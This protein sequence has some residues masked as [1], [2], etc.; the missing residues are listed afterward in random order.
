MPLNDYILGLN[1][2]AEFDLEVENIDLGATHVLTNE[3]GVY[4]FVLRFNG[5]SYRIYIGKA[6]NLNSRIANYRSNFQPHSPNDFKIRAFVEFINNEGY[7]GAELDLYF[8]PVPV[9]ELKQSEYDIIQR[10]NPILNIP[11]VGRLHIPNEY[12]FLKDAFIEFY[13]AGIRVRAN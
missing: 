6:K 11:V 3:P 2:L 13:K 9:D 5:A 10:F 8:K 12:V 7:E 1:D 4:F